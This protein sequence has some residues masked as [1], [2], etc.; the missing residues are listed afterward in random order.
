MKTSKLLSAFFISSLLGFTACT[1]RDVKVVDD[2]TRLKINS[3]KSG[4]GPR[5]QS[6]D[7][8]LGNYALSSFLMEKQ[9][10][11]VELVKLA[12]GSAEATKTQ[13]GVTALEDG[14]DG[15][16]NAT[17]T[18]SKDILEYTSDGAGWKAKVNK[19]LNVSYTLKD[20]SLETLKAS[21]TN[22]KS[23]VDSSDAQRTYVNLV[24]SNYSLSVG[25]ADKAENLKIELKSDGSISG[26]KGGKNIPNAV[27][28]SV[29]LVV[30]KASLA[31]QDVKIIS[32]TAAMTYPGPNG[33]VF[34]SNLD[35]GNLTLKADGLCNVLSGTVTAS[36]GPKNKYSVTFDGEQISIAGK[37]S[38]TLATCGKRPTVDLG[39][40][41]VY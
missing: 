13:F 8:S 20:G 6:G 11:A 4:G 5:S 21:G 31:T 23:S 41:Q 37:W 7:F 39:R 27:T 3:K 18:S 14:A 22:V 38:K 2:N 30:D 33:K 34:N 9:I 36:A 35:G 10:E 32:T 25:P 16:K 29:T 15:S 19:T 17:I 12:T 28:I 1:P 26:A 40:L 24:E